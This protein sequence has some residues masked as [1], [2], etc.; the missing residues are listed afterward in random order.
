QRII[1]HENLRF[2][3]D[4]PCNGNPLLLTT[5]QC[6]TTFTHPGTKTLREANDIFVNI[7][8]LGGLHDFRLIRIFDPECDVVEDGVAEEKYIL[9]HISDLTSQRIQIIMGDG[10]IVDEDLTVADIVKSR[11][12]V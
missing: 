8:I 3:Y 12:Q 5:R 1:E 11:Y 9:R 7:S 2:T 4:S 10:N 6:D